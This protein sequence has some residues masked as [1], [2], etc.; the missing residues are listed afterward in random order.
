MDSVAEG[1]DRDWQ[2]LLKK[3]GPIIRYL[4]KTELKYNNVGRSKINERKK[5]HNADTNYKKPGMVILI[6]FSPTN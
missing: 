3:Y 5:I 4:H 2:N 6:T 1:D